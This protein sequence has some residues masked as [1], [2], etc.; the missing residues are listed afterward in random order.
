[1][2]EQYRCTRNKLP[3]LYYSWCLVS[4]SRL[5]YLLPSVSWW[6]KGRAFQILGRRTW[7]CTSPGLNTPPSPRP[8]PAPHRLWTHTATP[9]SRH[10]WYW[11]AQQQTAERSEGIS[12][13]CAL[14]FT[15]H[16]CLYSQDDMEGASQSCLAKVAFCSHSQYIRDLLRGGIQQDWDMCV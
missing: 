14:Y 6:H 16:K 3:F 10:S 7:R 4:G 13:Q 5:N 11:S 8:P 1:M 2:E 12:Q 9:P 15:A